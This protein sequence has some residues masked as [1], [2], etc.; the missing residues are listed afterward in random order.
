MT[1]KKNTMK[2]AVL[3]L[4]ALAVASCSQKKFHIEGTISEAQDSMLYLENVGVENVT[5]VESVKLGADGTFSFS[6][7][8]AESPEFYRLRISDQIIDISID[9][10]E[11]VTVKAAYPTMI[12]Q[13]EVSGS[14]NCQKIKEITLKQI[15][16]QQRA[17]SLQ[18]SMSINAAADS[19]DKLIKAYREDVCNNYIYKDPKASYA[20]F[21]LFQTLGGLFIF[22]PQANPEDVK[23]FN[24]VATNWDVN[25]P[26]AM[27]TTNLHNIAINGM[28]TKRIKEYNNMQTIDAS[29]V[30][31]TGLIDFELT[32]NKGQTRRLS[33]LKGKV[34]LLDFHL[35]GMDDSPKRILALREIYNKY[36][37]QGFEIYQVA[38][39]SNEHFWK[40]QTAALPWISVRDPEGISS[41]RLVFYN[42]QAVP[43]F[44]LID[45]NN[46]IVMRQAQIGDVEEEIKKL[47]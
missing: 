41:Q 43:D 22:N 39:D 47:L 45:R 44:F 24:A 15:D 14:D 40:Q 16:L 31:T 8:Q 34:V 35:F 42:V 25:Y 6:G 28:K 30:E 9:S 1:I 36:S 23:A 32:D 26:D 38:L 17:I 21:A 7:E 12:T 10:T 20:Y 29:K 13:Y 4:A 27:R 33:D 37:A 18:R 3:M 5:T 46:N 11:T 19:I 2:A